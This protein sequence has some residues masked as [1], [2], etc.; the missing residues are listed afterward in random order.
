MPDDADLNAA[1]ASDPRSMIWSQVFVSGSKSRTRGSVAFACFLTTMSVLGCGASTQPDTTRTAEASPTEPV[2]TAT[3]CPLPQMDERRF[4]LHGGP[5]T[6]D[7]YEVHCNRECMRG[8]ARHC[9][10]LGVGYL[11][12]RVRG[13]RVARPANHDL[14]TELLLRGCQL[15]LP[16]SC[17]EW[18]LAVGRAS[19]VNQCQRPVMERACALDVALGC[20]AAGTYAA[21]AGERDE[22]REFEHRACDLG[23]YDTCARLA[24]TTDANAPG[25]LETLRRLLFAGCFRGEHLRSC[26]RLAEA[27]DDGPFATDTANEASVAWEQACRLDQRYCSRVPPPRPPPVGTDASAATLYADPSAPAAGTPPDTGDRRGALSAD[28]IRTTVRANQHRVQACY[29]TAL[30][31][32]STLRGTVTVR[33]IIQPDG[34]VSTATVLSDTAGDARLRACIAASVATWRF[35]AP[36]GGGLVSVTYPFTLDSH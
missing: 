4:A 13:R 5:T 11:Q 27:L 35:P 26:V 31:R 22:A 28:V 33:F 2:A 7:S 25:G 6:C 15:G 24:E 32:R 29:E 1:R 19:D 8:D 21:D 36:D 34:T 10:L 9:Q 16:E 18:V 12:P 20:V 17:V 14:A 30:A 3:V 23:D